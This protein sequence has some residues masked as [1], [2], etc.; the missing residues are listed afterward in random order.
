MSINQ[1]RVPLQQVVV[2]TKNGKSG[3]PFYYFE[4]LEPQW[5]FLQTE[6]NPRVEMMLKQLAESGEPIDLNV[7]LKKDSFVVDEQS[8]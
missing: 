4:V 1:I 7:C 2:K 8:F 3:S 5:K 6:N